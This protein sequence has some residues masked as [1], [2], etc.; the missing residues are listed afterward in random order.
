MVSSLKIMLR[1][2]SYGVLTLTN[3]SCL[4][5]WLKIVNRILLQREK[6]QVSRSLEV[7]GRQTGMGE[8][9]KYP[10]LYHGRLLGFPKGR[11]GSLNWNSEGMGGYLQL[12]NIWRHGGGFMGGISRIERVEW[13]PW[14]HYCC[15]LLQFVNKPRTYD[16]G[17]RRQ[18]SID[19]TCRSEQ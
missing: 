11:G 13:V 10:Y 12:E 3:L 5:V 17:S 7:L 6:V 2:N 18:A 14:K 15:R 19:Q 4:I 9:R 16:R 1:R 8:S